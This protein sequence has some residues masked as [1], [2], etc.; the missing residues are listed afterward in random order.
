[1]K[2]RVLTVDCLGYP[3]GTPLYPLLVPDYGVSRGDTAV[4]NEPCTS[5]SLSPLG[6]YPFLCVPDGITKEAP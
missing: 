5:W 1:M 4:F 2:T 3:A 6:G